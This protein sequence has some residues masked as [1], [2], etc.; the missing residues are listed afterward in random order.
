MMPCGG[1]FRHAYDMA[2]I[3]ELAQQHSCSAHGMIVLPVSK[4]AECA[5]RDCAP[6]FYA[7]RPG[8]VSQCDLLI[9]HIADFMLPLSGH[10][11][12][13]LIQS[14]MEEFIRSCDKYKILKQI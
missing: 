4:Q 9:S 12:I 11:D 7:F 3:Q 5:V 6:L 8:Q 2:D 13:W 10:I 14:E 1:V